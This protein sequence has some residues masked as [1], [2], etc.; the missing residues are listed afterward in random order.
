MVWIPCDIITS[1]RPHLLGIWHL[2]NS[3]VGDHA[4]TL[5]PCRDRPEEC[6]NSQELLFFVSAECSFIPVNGCAQVLVLEAAL[7]MLEGAVLGPWAQHPLLYKT[8]VGGLSGCPSLPRVGAL[9]FP[10]PLPSL[11]IYIQHLSF[12][13]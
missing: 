4:C 7:R 5:R 13:F 11:L 8:Y 10:Y 9:L 2:N 6:K 12:A 1:S 3:C